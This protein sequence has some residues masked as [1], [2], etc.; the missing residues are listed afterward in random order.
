MSSADLQP[1]IGGVD[2]AHMAYEEQVSLASLLLRQ[3]CTNLPSLLSSE[4]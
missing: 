1:L 2:P 4:A 3:S